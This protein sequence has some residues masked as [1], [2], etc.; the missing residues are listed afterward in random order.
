[1]PSRNQDSVDKQSL[2]NFLKRVPALSEVLD[3]HSQLVAHFG[4]FLSEE[5]VETDI[6]P[7]KIRACYEAAAIRPPANITDAMRKSHAFIRTSGGTKLHRD[8]RLRIKAS[9]ATLQIELN[10]V[11]SVSSSA[12]TYTEKARKVVVI[13]GRDS[14]IRNG[15]FE[16]LRSLGLAPIEWSEAVAR[17]GSGT[18]YTGEVVEELFRDAQ[19]IVVILSPD[20]YTELRED[21]QDEGSVE[22][23]GWQPRPNV[24]IEA[25]MALA[26]DEKHTICVEIGKVRQASDL[27]GRNVVRFDGSPAHR[28]ELAERLRTAGCEVATSGTDWLRA[29]NFGVP[30][31]SAKERRGRKK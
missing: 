22:N 24:F 6:T 1:M 16:L 4:Y 5:A 23:R 27:F 10:A 20:E 7:G 15:M 25:G 14:G 2:E 18:P 26:K 28:H 30:T 8:F 17:T 21:L 11:A 31:T 9:L 19:A 3:N 12:R 29:G 13:H